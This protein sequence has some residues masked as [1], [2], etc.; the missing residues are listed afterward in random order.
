MRFL[1]FLSV[2]A[3]L[4]ASKVSFAQM[5]NLETVTYSF[6][7]K[8]DGVI[9]LN[10]NL[11]TTIYA[12]FT[13]SR[14]LS[15][16]TSTWSNLPIKAEI[17]LTFLS[18]EVPETL[19]TVIPVSNSDWVGSTFA[20]SRT[21]SKDITI[22][23]GV[24]TPANPN[25]SIVAKWRYYKEGYPSPYNTDG[26][27]DWETKKS[28]PMKLNPDKIPPA[29]FTGPSQICSEGTYT[30]TNPYNISLE[31]ASG[32][33]TLTALGNNQWKVTRIGNASGFVKL[34]ST[35]NGKIIE[36]EV[37]V[38]TPKPVIY[39]PV[40][41]I[42]APR[43]SGGITDASFWVDKELS[44][45]TYEWEIFG[46]GRI[47]FPNGNTGKNVTI[48]VKSHEGTI[49]YPCKM[50]LRITNSCGTSEDIF[51]NFTVTPTGGGVAEE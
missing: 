25:A 36:K 37:A 10:Y 13:V 20:I 8:E 29:S 33:A 23:A 3:L 21:I 9:L 41:T 12:S 49:P 24:V 15:G 1:R 19:I 4:I 22:P 11:P 18:A 46:S 42:S 5:L 16:A 40:A 48:H 34:R 35:L 38:G 14:I 51:Y 6:V 26:W 30:I 43:G 2:L 7:P 39:G 28:N 32:I 44:G 45:A 31:N 27:T 47:I 50:R 17:A